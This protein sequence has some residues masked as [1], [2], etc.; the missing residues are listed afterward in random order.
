[1]DRASLNK[2]LLDELEKMPNVKFYFNHKLTGVDFNRNLAWIETRDKP[3][4]DNAQR[5]P[6]VEIKFDFM[7]GA[8]GAHSA[9]RFHLMKFAR[10]S[11]QQEYIDTLW[12]EFHMDA[13]TTADGTEDFKIHP[14]RLHIWPAGDFMFIA[15]PSNDKTFTCTLFMPH[16]HFTRLDADHASIVPFFEQ[17]FPG[18]TDELISRD[19]LQKQYLEN[20]HL[21]LISIKCSPHHF[22][23]S[24]VIV[25]DASHAMVPFYGQGMNTGLED[26][27][28]LFEVLDK[29]K[30]TSEAAASVATARARALEEYS[31]LRVPDTAAITNL[32]LDNYKEMRSD[33]LSPV[34]KLRK[35]IE[36]KLSVWL[37]SLG[38][39]TQYS[40]V[41]FGNERY[42]EVEKQT[43]HQGRVLERAMLATLFGSLGVL[44]VLLG[45]LLRND[46]FLIAFRSM[47]QKVGLRR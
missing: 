20:P 19:D 30:P 22:G 16:K 14:N 41:S 23:S 9:A 32:A 12:C 15:I 18:I 38:W 36:E 24:G 4:Q 45:R 33:V 8:D 39:A 37:P 28:V 2:R 5:H 1:M 26:V 34:Y 35:A 11:Y 25:G 46:R 17:Y 27:R 3:K 40:R 47:A 13:K 31:A 7:I 43:K 10:M 42:S 6:E 21:P 44:G 29:H